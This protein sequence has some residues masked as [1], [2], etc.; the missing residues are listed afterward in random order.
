[1]SIFN[2]F[3]NDSEKAVAT[4]SNEQVEVQLPEQSTEPM[5]MG[6]EKKPLTVSYATGWPIDVIYG[7]LHKDY[8]T[9]GYEDAMIKSD[10]AF[11]DMNMNI[12]KNK[13][14]MVFREINLNYDVMMHD[15]ESRMETCNAAGLLTTVT[16]MEARLTIINTHKQELLRL[17]QDFRQGVNEAAMPLKTYECGF[18]RG[19]AT[20][21]MTSPTTAHASM[22][23]KMAIA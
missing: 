10:L 21:A 18:L 9:K 23:P 17:E 6:Q 8:A 11:R 15:V 4:V 20:I 13:I 14:L 2:F 19:V 1:M 22:T 3:K 5:Q 16:D 7:Y 12:I